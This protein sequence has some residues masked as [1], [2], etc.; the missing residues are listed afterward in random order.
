MTCAIKPRT[1]PAEITL[2]SAAPADAAMMLVVGRLDK[3][4]RHLAAGL[5]HL[6]DKPGLLHG[7]YPLI[8]LVGDHEGPQQGVLRHQ[9]NI[10]ASVKK[11]FSRIRSL[12]W[13][14]YQ[15]PRP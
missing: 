14:R 5:S 13:R 12:G 1:A 7:R 8:L 4:L 6:F 2:R 10:L 3:E 11:G 9:R 15:R